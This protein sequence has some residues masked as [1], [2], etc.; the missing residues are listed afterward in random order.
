MQSDLFEIP[1]P[2][3]QT[4][5][6]QRFAFLESYRFSLRLDQALIGTI[7]LIMIYVLVF[8]FGVE[9]GKQFALVELKAE[10][11]K[12]E[13]MVQE[14]SQKLIEKSS[15]L[16]AKKK[17]LSLT[18][19]AT[20]KAVAT[21]PVNESRTEIKRTIPAGQYTLQVATYTKKQKAAADSLVKDLL[22]KGMKGFV[23][24]SSSH[25]AICVEAFENHS[26]AKK[27]LAELKAQK[28]IPTDAYIRGI[29]Q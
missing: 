26:S 7:V 29:P 10:R 25:L 9:K 13:R 28:M 4:Q 23:I 1:V 18:V 19:P 17:S 5:T 21:P 11:L 2:N 12:R 3:I 16:T 20:A 27:I 24:P 22:Q 6:A 14:L 8:S 15:E